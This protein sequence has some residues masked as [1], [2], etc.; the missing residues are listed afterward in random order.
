MTMSG[1]VLGLGLEKAV[2]ADLWVEVSAAEVVK[3]G[4]HTPSTGVPD[5]PPGL[6]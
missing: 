1:L 6:L 4:S 2:L 5:T 3:V